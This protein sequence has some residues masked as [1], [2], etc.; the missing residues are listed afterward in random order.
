MRYAQYFWRMYFERRDL[1][2]AEYL[3]LWRLGRAGGGIAGWKRVDIVDFFLG[4]WVEV[5]KE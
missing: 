4:G 3:Y 2:I 1:S 5:S